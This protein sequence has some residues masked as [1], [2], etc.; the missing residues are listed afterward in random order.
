MEE[1]DKRCNPT[2]RG[3]HGLLAVESGE[4]VML[5]LP[6]LE[7]SHWRGIVAHTETVRGS[8]LCPQLRNPHSDIR[9]SRRIGHASR[10][11]GTYK[12]SLLRC[13]PHISSCTRGK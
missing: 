13:V 10:Y 6:L 4:L 5:R 1:V 9:V 7:E 12:S 3:C 8:P 2:Q 11:W